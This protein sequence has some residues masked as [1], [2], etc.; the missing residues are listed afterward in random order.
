MPNGQ[1]R[2]HAEVKVTIDGREARINVFADTLNEIFLDIG[3]ICEQIP[4]PFQNGAHREIANAELK[5]QQLRQQGKL[6]SH[7][8]KK[9]PPPTPVCPN[10]GSTNTE[11]IKWTDKQTGEARQEWKCQHCKQWLPPVRKA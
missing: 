4:G 7:V 9:L 1:T 8:S 10:C 6:P 2:Y 11:L 5:A 3:T